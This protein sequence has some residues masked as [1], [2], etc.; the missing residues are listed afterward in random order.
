MNKDKAFFICSQKKNAQLVYLGY[1]YNK[2][3]TQNNGHTTWRCC[4]MAK[5]NC[6]AVCTTVNSELVSVRRTHTHRPHWERFAN[7]ELYSSEHQIAEHEH[8]TILPRPISIDVD[9]HAKN[10]G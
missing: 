5:L 10:N 8:V 1:I 7:R 3:Q 4:E 9:S 6:R 2:K